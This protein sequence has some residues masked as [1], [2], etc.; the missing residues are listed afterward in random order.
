MLFKSVFFIS[1]FFMAGAVSS[2]SYQCMPCPVGVNCPTGTTEAQVSSQLAAQAQKDGTPVGSIIALAIGRGTEITDGGWLL[3]NGQVIPSGTK[4]D[5]LR[6]LLGN[7][8]GAG[9]VP[10]FQ[11]RFLRGYGGN[12]S[13]I[14]TRQDESIP[15]ITGSTRSFHGVFRGETGFDSGVFTGTYDDSIHIS[16]PFFQTSSSTT[17]LSFSVNRSHAAYGRRNEVAPTNYAVYYYIK[18]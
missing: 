16:S 15:N 12:S 8:Y 14:G 17:I 5:A 13:S 2:A 1:A 18:Y 9:R 4:Y 7:T 10:D 6:N 11:G 3:C